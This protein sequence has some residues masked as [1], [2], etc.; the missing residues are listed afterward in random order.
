M[1]LGD[2]PGNEIAHTTAAVMLGGLPPSALWSHLLV[3][4]LCLAFAPGEPEAA[5][6]RLDD[7]DPVGLGSV[8]IHGRRPSQASF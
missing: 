2:V 6:E 7:L 3:P 5:E 1:V 8:P 4:A